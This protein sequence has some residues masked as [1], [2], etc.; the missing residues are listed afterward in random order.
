MWELAL[1]VDDKRD[2]TFI[3]HHRA[4]PRGTPNVYKVPI[5]WDGHSIN[6]RGLFPAG[7]GAGYAGGIVSAALD[8]LRVAQALTDR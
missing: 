8:G 2:F 5:S 6:T 1:C 7:E 3:P 4:S